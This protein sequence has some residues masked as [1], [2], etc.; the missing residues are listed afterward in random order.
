MFL[1]SI[2]A[3]VKT[4]GNACC[5][6]VTINGATYD[7]YHER[8]TYQLPLS[9]CK[10]LCNQDPNCKGYVQTPQV[11]PGQLEYCEVATTSPC[12]KDS[13]GRKFHSGTNGKLLDSAACG[14]GSGPGGYDG[15]YIKQSAGKKL[16]FCNIVD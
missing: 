9:D 11:F 6:N 4:N 10:R 8:C 7:G 5:T 16:I 1:L 15:C 13:T 12:D 14:R 3:Y 2:I